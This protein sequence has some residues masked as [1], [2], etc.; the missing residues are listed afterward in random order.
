MASRTAWMRPSAVEGVVNSSSSD[1]VTFTFDA[2]GIAS[3][4]VLTDNFLIYHN[5]SKEDSPIEVLCTLHVNTVEI[6]VDNDPSLNEIVS[7]I[8]VPNLVDLSQDNEVVLIYNAKA[9]IV[10][11]QMVIYDA[12]GNA[13]DQSSDV[14][15]KYTWDLHNKYGRRVSGGMYLAILKLIDDSGNKIVKKTKIG[16]IER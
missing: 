11:A 14:G 6:V 7:F 5:S 15:N 4:T 13:I 16:I 2:K 1:K 12:L 3:G 8:A 9:R 10:E